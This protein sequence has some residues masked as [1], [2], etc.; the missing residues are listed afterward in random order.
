MNADRCFLSAVR[1]GSIK[2]QKFLNFFLMEFEFL[3]FMTESI[4]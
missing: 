2:R 1:I 4:I 3:V